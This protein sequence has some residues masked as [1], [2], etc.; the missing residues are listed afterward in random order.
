[1]TETQE[2]DTPEL[3]EG[4]PAPAETPTESTEQSSVSIVEGDAEQQPTE[5]STPPAEP[6]SEAPAAVV[7]E[8]APETYEQFSTPGGVDSLDSDVLA[9]FETTAKE[10]DLPQ[11]KAQS[12]IDSVAPRIAERQKQV[13]ATQVQTWA[14]EVAS[15]PEIGGAKLDESVGLARKAYRMGASNELQSLLKTSG[16]DVHPE[17][18][19]MFRYFGSRLSE[20]KVVKG[21]D[22]P[23]TKGLSGD[24]FNNPGP[25]M[26]RLY[27][28]KK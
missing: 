12:L 17:M 22:A 16:L 14:N 20:D 4:T 6:G 24:V 26:D 11:D 1:V 27:G 21:G 28:K 18:V 7:P 15:D 9:T 13:L 10:L 2:T 8:G 3:Q 19:R 5:Q 23:A 25:T